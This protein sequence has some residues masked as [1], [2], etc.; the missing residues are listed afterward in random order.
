MAGGW[1]GGG[2]ELYTLG[3]NSSLCFLTCCGGCDHPEEDKGELRKQMELVFLRKGLGQQFKYCQSFFYFQV[4]SR[5][6]L[7]SPLPS[8]VHTLSPLDY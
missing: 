5:I 4:I 7:V 1:G 6:K 8:P 2:G 3:A